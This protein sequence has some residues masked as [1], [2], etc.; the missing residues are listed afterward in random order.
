MLVTASVRFIFFIF[1]LMFWIKMS[2]MYTRAYSRLYKGQGAGMEKG[3]F[4]QAT[5]H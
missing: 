4:E 1:V 5:L 3:N 2:Y